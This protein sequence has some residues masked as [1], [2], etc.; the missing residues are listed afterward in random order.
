MWHRLDFEDLVLQY[1]EFSA[2]VRHLFLLHYQ[3]FFI[4]CLYWKRKVSGNLGWSFLCLQEMQFW[5]MDF[6][7]VLYFGIE[8]KLHRKIA[9][10]FVVEICRA[11]GARAEKLLIIIWLVKRLEGEKI[12]K[13]QK[14]SVGVWKALVKSCSFFSSLLVWVWGYTGWTFNGQCFLKWFWAHV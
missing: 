4:F 10:I 6:R 9:L 11:H 1:L 5:R 8:L 3:K 2:C 12:E 14:N 7:A 13:K